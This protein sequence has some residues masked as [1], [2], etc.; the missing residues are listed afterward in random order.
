MFRVNIACNLWDLAD[1]GIEGTLDRI[2]ST[3]AAGVT[4]IVTSAPIAQIRCLDVD[5]RIFRSR[6]GFFFRPDEECYV[7]TRAKP[8]LSTWLKSRDPMTD[9]VTAIRKRGLGLH[10][11]ISAFETGRI[12]QRHPETAAKTAFGDAA[13]N[14]LCPANAEIRALLRATAVDLEQRCRPDAIELADL[15]YHSGA[16]TGA[17]LEMDF[18]PGAGF[19]A[20]LNLCFCESSRQWA[21]ERGIDAAAAAR[22]AAVQMEKVLVTGRPCTHT[23]D[24]L[25][26][27]ADIPGRYVAAQAEALDSLIEHIAD[28]VQAPLV[29]ALPPEA[30]SGLLPSAKVFTGNTTPLIQLDD[31]DRDSLEGLLEHQRTRFGSAISPTFE[32]NAAAAAPQDLVSMLKHVADAGVPSVTIGSFALIPPDTLEPVKQAIRYATRSVP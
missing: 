16:T 14:T 2:Q 30:G 13:D 9:A 1:A 24:E 7:D 18:E 3:G 23:L 26:T 29:L 25:L 31:I 28:R 5:P 20:L 6:G 22:W 8:V 12:G 32:L 19:F 4:L 11:R 15:R 27:G 17:G 10:L 21:D